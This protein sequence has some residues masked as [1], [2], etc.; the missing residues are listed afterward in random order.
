MRCWNVRTATPRRSRGRSCV[1]CRN[2]CPLWLYPITG[3]GAPRHCWP[4][5]GLAH[6]AQGNGEWAASVTVAT[7]DD[8]IADALSDEPVT[9]VM[10]AKDHTSGTDRLAEV[11]TKKGWDDDVI[12]VNLQGDE[13]LMPAENIAQV[14]SL[15]A[16]Y[17]DAAISTLWEPITNR[18]EFL[19]P[20]AVKLVADASG[21]A[22]YFSRAPIP[23]P[24]DTFE[25]LSTPVS[26]CRHIGL[27]AYRA[28]FL[29]AFTA[30]APSPL[31]RLESL[32]QL[33]ALE[34]G[35]VIM[36]APAVVTVP[37]GVDT[38]DDLARVRECMEVGKC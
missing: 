34:A 9:V 37:A 31:E 30:M 19:N 23:W 4:P 38:P 13:P 1:S 35:E 27:Y 21:R 2:S 32:E 36:V 17:S 10:T 29:R 8:R 24:R 25:D 7:D 3:Q 33:R 15:L 22:L 5:H 26:A 6:V 18:E 12:V 11:A 16:R 20:A 28:G 14:A